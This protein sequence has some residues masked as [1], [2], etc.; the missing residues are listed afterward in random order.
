MSPHFISSLAGFIFGSFLFLII[1][2][3]VIVA[4]FILFKTGVSG[5]WKKIP[6]SSAFFRVNERTSNRSH[7]KKD[8]QK[9]RARLP[10]FFALY[11][12]L[13]SFINCFYN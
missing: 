5:S 6:A 10:V 7:S 8:D 9:C 2:G 4:K 1:S 12:L 13:F 3:V 11:G